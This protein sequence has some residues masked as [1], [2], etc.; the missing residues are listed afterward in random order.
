MG[1]RLTFIEYFPGSARVLSTL[2]VFTP[3]LLTV[4]QMIWYCF[5]L[6]FFFLFWYYFYA[7]FTDQEMR[8]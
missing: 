7:H 1:I 6:S 4:T 2:S 8:H 3:L 5:F